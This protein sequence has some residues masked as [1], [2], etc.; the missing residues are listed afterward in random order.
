VIPVLFSDAILAGRPIRLSNAGQHSRDFTFVDDIVEGMI[1]ASDRIT[2]PDPDWGPATENSNLRRSSSAVSHHGPH[3]R[4]TS[5][6]DDE[7]I[8]LTN[9][10]FV[11]QPKRWLIERTF[12]LAIINRR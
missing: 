5:F 9:A 4:R 12:A 6:M 7:I 2:L 10:G 1:R 11:V 3:K 8:K